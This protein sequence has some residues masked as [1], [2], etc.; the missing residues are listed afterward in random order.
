MARWQTIQLVIEAM[1]HVDGDNA[2]RSPD[3]SP[4]GSAI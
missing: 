4:A 3:S 1:S 2:T